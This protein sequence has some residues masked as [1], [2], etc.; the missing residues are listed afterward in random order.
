MLMVVAGTIDQLIDGFGFISFIFYTLVIIAVFILRITHHKEPRLFKV[1]TYSNNMGKLL[2]YMCVFCFLAMVHLAS[3][4]I[5]DPI[6]SL[7]GICSS[8]VSSHPTTN[9]L[10]VFASG[11]TCILLFGHGKSLETTT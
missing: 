9:S 3:G 10:W 11:S 6:L 1:G 7:C 5:H 8:S 2:L 4:Y